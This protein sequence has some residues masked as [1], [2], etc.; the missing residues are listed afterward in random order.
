MS[1]ADSAPSARSVGSYL[2]E[3][4]ES[5]GITLEEAARVTRIGKNYLTALE[6]GRFHTLPNIAY[7][8]G[9]LRAYAAFLGL[10][11][12]EVIAMYERGD[13]SPPHP[14]AEAKR[15]PGAP[16]TGE[17]RVSRGGRWFVPFILLALVVAAAYILDDDGPQPEKTPPPIDASQAVQVAAPVQPPRS[18]AQVEPK[19]PEVPADRGKGDP[20]EA[21]AAPR[22]IV[23]K[24]KVNQD[25]WLNITIDDTVSQQYDLKAGDLIE[26]KG[27][28]VFNLELG[29]GGGVEA[30][31]NNK[32]LKPF[33]EPGQP[34]HV[35][36]KAD[37][38]TP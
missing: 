13:S 23:L 37:G 3:C 6:E 25:S 1:V 26:W 31:L 32:P 36:L 9:F 10:S 11:G 5:Q 16:D 19:P 4:R 18:S 7:A 12:D 22:G 33:G 27:D 30:E 38:T 29:N 24:M 17:A 21:N 20:G 2:R 34:A 35:V 28:R 8:K 14:P 15:V